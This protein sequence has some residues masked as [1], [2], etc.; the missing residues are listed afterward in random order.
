MK[1]FISHTTSDKPLVDALRALITAT[2][3]EPVEVAYSSASV[4]EGGISAGQDWLDWI[5]A[6]VQDSAMAIVVVTPL[7]KSRPW[8][9][10]EA[11]AVS[12]VGLARKTNLPVVP[13]LFGLAGDQVPD[14][15]VSRQVKMG[16]SQVDIRDLLE[17]IARGGA[18]TYRPADALASAVQ[19]YCA[20]V[21]AARIPGMHDVFISCPMTSLAE[22]EYA[23]MRDT[24]EKLTDA[25][26]AKGFTAYSAVRR[27]S[28]QDSVDPESIAAEQDLPALTMS[29][30]FL[31]IY[32]GRI[33]SSCLLEA[34]YALV[35]GIPSLYFVKSDD[36]LP[37]LLRGAVESFRNTRRV[38]FRD[39]KEIVSFF[40][41]YPSKVII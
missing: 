35:A 11:G 3:V 18:L 6:Q 5:R 4:S 28:T 33:L 41:R 16:T 34:G 12:G 37:Y 15:L 13:L 7:S 20:T 14:P 9:M 8:L 19:T 23:K 29:R 22:G 36:D 39:A 31:M 38:K 30:N 2:F 32:P 21:T 26:N 24:I 1:V 25:I 40:E 27:I 17:S 10:W